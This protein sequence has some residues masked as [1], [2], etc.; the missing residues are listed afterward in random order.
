MEM[1]APP[2]MHNS[3]G[4]NLLQGRS[5]AFVMRAF[6]LRSAERQVELQ[7][8]PPNESRGEQPAATQVRSLSAGWIGL[9]ILVPLVF[10]FISAGVWRTI[11]SVRR[12][13]GDPASNNSLFHVIKGSRSG[14]STTGEP[15]SRSSANN[16]EKKAW[17][18]NEMMPASA[19]SMVIAASS[20]INGGDQ[21]AKES[22]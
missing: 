3:T 6:T 16:E 17:N 1:Y 20:I 12:T 14:A 11:R 8:V 18:A 4:Y 10:C 7:E 9:T 15:R 21:E 22:E 13:T 2:N 19:P 5:L